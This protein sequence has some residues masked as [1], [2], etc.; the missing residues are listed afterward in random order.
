MKQ[1]RIGVRFFLPLFVS[2]AICAVGNA[3]QRDAPDPLPRAHAHNDYWH[4][5]PLLD[6]LGHG[7]CS[8]EADVFLVDGRLLVGHGRFELTPARTLEVLYLDPLKERVTANEG[9]VYPQRAPFTLMIDI[10]SDAVE[11][12]RALSQLLSRYADMLTKIESG[13]ITPGPVTIVLSGNRAT[14]L[15]ASEPIRFAMVDGRLSDLDSDKRA[16]LISWISD[17]WTTH[18]RWRGDG[19]MAEPERRQ[20][21][22]IVTK[23]HRAG[24]RVRFW[25]TPD[26]RSVWRELCAAGVDLIN[27]DDL[28]GLQAFLLEERTK[29]DG[30]ELRFDGEDRLPE[31]RFDRKPARIHT[32]GLYVTAQHYYVTGRLESEPRRPLLIRFDRRQAERVESIDLASALRGRIAQAEH[33]DHPGGFD[34]DG[35]RFWIPL[36]ESRPHA[37]TVVLT[38]RLQSTIRPMLRSCLRKLS[39]LEGIKRIG[40]VPTRSA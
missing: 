1:Q 32:Q 30:I 38:S 7:F 5:R 4:K 24:R 21:R 18:F 19:A 2:V 6:A 12:Y 35:R 25:A 29:I 33:L 11:T 40:C 8:V 13:R 36:S 22:A 14:D 15:I 28:S 39:I 37:K 23:A 16:S 31:V 17:R 26:R 3:Q 10:K 20:L 9:N 34:F 27:A